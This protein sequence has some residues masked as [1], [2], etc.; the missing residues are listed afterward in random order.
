[1]RERGRRQHRDQLPPEKKETQR[2]LEVMKE[3]REVMAMHAPG[4]R[5]WFQLDREGDAWPMLL[6]AGLDGHWFTIRAS[7]NRRV[8]LP[9]GERSYLRS[10][11]AGEPVKT[12]YQLEVR[13]TAHRKGRTA[14]MVV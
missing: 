12:E 10:L 9:N 13:A 5:C 8:R 7:R 1:W 3:T 2:W 14:N 11:L 4:T 6:D